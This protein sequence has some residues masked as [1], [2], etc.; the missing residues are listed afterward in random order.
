METRRMFI[1]ACFCVGCFILAVLHTFV[2]A[3]G[4]GSTQ[5]V[6]NQEA[7]T[8]GDRMGNYTLQDSKANH[9]TFP[10]TTS[11][12][13]NCGQGDFEITWKNERL[14]VLYHNCSRTDAADRFFEFMRKYVSEGYYIIKRE[15][16]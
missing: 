4:E 7:E 3:E 8:P 13:I 16:E 1:L 10:V 12:N 2:S 15:K 6:V 11:I 14:D 5:V 9:F